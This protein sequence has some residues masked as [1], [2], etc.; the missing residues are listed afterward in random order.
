MARPR[1]FDEGTVLEAA[2]LCVWK[3]GYEAT[4]VGDLVAQTGITA[5]RGRLAEV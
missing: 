4:S 2:V 5:V 1:E 3:Q